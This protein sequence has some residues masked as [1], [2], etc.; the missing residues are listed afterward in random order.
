M[1]IAVIRKILTLALTANFLAL[2]I[3]SDLTYGQSFDLITKGDL[4]W[5]VNAFARKDRR[6]SISIAF[7]AL[8]KVN[9]RNWDDFERW[10]FPGIV[11]ERNRLIEISTRHSQQRKTSKESMAGRTDIMS[12]LLAA[13]DPKTGSK[14]I[15]AELWEEAQLMI[16]AGRPNIL[17]ALMVFAKT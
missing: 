3:M 9:L 6:S 13:R 12:T 11:N 10:I 7:A 8:F 5:L 1:A 14:F 4:R 15:E 2:D 16:A 17:F